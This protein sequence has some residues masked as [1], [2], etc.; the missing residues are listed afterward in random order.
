MGAASIRT[1]ESFERLLKPVFSATIPV[2]V[3]NPEFWRELEETYLENGDPES[4]TTDMWRNA[5]IYVGMDTAYVRYIVEYGLALE[6][7]STPFHMA[8]FRFNPSENMQDPV[9]VPVSGVSKFQNQ[10]FVN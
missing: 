1:R 8:N 2:D 9:R 7:T 4:A 6:Q 10:T 5:Y 3:E